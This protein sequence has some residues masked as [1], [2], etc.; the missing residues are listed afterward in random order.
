M[1]DEDKTKYFELVQV[2]KEL[3]MKQDYEGA[4]KVR[5]EERDLL[6]KYGYIIPSKRK[7]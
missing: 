2:K 3:V 1:S 7:K 5:T 6:E 4:S